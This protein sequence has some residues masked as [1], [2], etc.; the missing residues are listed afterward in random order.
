[1]RRLQTTI[2]P[3]VKASRHTPGER[4]GR[5][6]QPASPQAARLAAKLA[7]TIGAKWAGKPA[8]SVA[9]RVAT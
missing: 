6:A 7:A 1:M 2:N 4:F 5:P 9:G 3:K 8:G